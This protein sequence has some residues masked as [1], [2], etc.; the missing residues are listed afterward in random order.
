MDFR[1]SPLMPNSEAFKLS[2]VGNKG[3][4]KVTYT[5]LFTAWPPYSIL[6]RSMSGPS[7]NAYTD[8]KVSIKLDY[9]C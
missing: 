9:L 3:A 6:S 7:C 2:I 5:A 8:M 1:A 4:G